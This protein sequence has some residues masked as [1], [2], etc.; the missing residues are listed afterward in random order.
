MQKGY[1]SLDIDKA[2]DYLKEKTYINDAMF[3]EAYLRS[4]CSKKGKP[5]IAV[6]Q[7]LREKWVPK[8]IIQE[9]SRKMEQEIQEW[10]YEKI[11]KDIEVCKKR[12]EEGFDI[13]QRLMKKGYRLDDIKRVIK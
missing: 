11:K 12:G 1:F 2:I 4:E 3:T 5:M 6:T 8:E 9:V 13:I 10:I 7:K